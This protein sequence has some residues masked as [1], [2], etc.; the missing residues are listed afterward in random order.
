MQ[1]SV[2]IPTF[3]RSSMIVETLDSVFAQRLADFEVLVV[4]DGSTDDTVAILQTYAGRLRVLVQPNRGPGAARN[5]AAEHARGE[6]LAFLD[7]DDMWFPWTLETYAQVLRGSTDAPALVVGKP[8]VF[9][10]TEDL[11]KIDDAPCTVTAFS[12]YY[13]SG[14]EWRWYGASSFVIRADAFRAVGGFAPVWI[15]GEDA[16]LAMRLG[17]SAGFVQ[18]TSPMTFG[19]RD[20]GG[21][22]VSQTGRTLAGVQFQLRTELDGGYPGGASR[23]RERREILTRQVRPM[24]LTCLAERRFAA[25]WQLYWSTWSWHLALGRLRFLLGFPLLALQAV[26]RGHDRRIA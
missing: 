17:T 19:Y 20:H 7:S 12:D 8:Q 4:D 24:I 25:A 16:D 13:A 10:R 6:Y 9:G 11:R 23:A 14:D 5:L 1:F 21:S 18:V 22:L 15:N 2:I 3:N 26:M